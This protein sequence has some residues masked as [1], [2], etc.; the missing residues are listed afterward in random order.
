MKCQACA[1]EATVHVTEI[2]AGKPVEY[3]VCGTHLQGLDTLAPA[4]V[5]TEPARGIGAFFNDARLREAWRDPA[6]RE[7]IAAHLVPALCLAL[8]DQNA[9]V[10]VHAA[11]RLMALG[12]DARSALG[13]LRDALRDPDERVRAAAEIAV[14]YI[15]TE[16]DPGWQFYWQ[17]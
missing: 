1:E 17:F 4:G 5:F 7:T 12:G 8:L 9:A 16:P 11:F 14:E 13:A 2:V 15:Q 10:R 6:A 3:H